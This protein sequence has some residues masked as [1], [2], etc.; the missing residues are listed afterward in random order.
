MRSFAEYCL[1]REGVGPDAATLYQ[2]LAAKIQQ[3][4]GG[5]PGGT[6]TGTFF[7]SLGFDVPTLFK[8]NVIQRGPEGNFQLN[9]AMQG[10]TARRP[11]PAAPQQPSMFSKMQT[12]PSPPPPPPVPQRPGM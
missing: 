5:P 2:T 12:M 10:M 4:T 7:N 9:Q 1:W 6:Y 3:K 11:Q 8:A